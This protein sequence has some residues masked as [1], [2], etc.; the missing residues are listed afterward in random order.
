MTLPPEQSEALLQLAARVEA[1]SGPDRELDA[2]IW[3]AVNGKEFPQP[4]YTTIYKN[5]EGEHS[6]ITH[7]GLM[8]Q[9]RIDQ[10][11]NYTASLNAATAL[12]PE[13]WRFMAG[14]REFPHARAYVENGKPAFVGIGNRRNPERLWAETTAA[15]P[16]LAL[17]AAALRA[18]SLALQPGGEK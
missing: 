10:S 9:C 16:A 1:A 17:T 8:R 2:A 12:V 7:S 5:Y 15:T 3:C 11:L 6:G 14:Q 18:R 4:P 13:G